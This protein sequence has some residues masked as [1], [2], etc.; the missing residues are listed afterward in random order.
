MRRGQLLP[1]DVELL[2]RAGYEASSSAKPTPR[3]IPLEEQ[4]RLHR[5]K[6]RRIVRARRRKAFAERWMR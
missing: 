3:K 2:R 4:L 6:R 5:V 1:I